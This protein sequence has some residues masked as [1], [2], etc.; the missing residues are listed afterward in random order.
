[1]RSLQTVKE[2]VTTLAKNNG[3]LTKSDPETVDL[4]AVYFQEV[5]TKEN[6]ASIPAVEEK[7]LNWRD[8]D[9]DFSIETVS[10]KLQ[11]LQADKSPGPDGIHPLLLK[12]CSSIVALPLSLIFRKSFETGELPADWRAAHIVPIFKKGSKTD[13]AN[14]RPVSLTSVSCKVMESIIKDKLLEFLD[15]NKVISE[16]QHGFRSGRSCLTNLLESFEQWTRA[17]DEGFGLDVLYLDFR[18]AFDSV[19]HRRLI[20]KLKM[21]GFSGK[22]L[23]WIKSFLTVR[24][25]LVGIRGAFSQLI[26]VLSG[27]PQGSVLDP[28]LSLLF[29]NELPEWIRGSM[30]MFADDTKLWCK[31]KIQSDGEQL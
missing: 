27:V 30:K 20:E 11:K 25:M 1:M 21:Y 2:N 7:D 18:K 29:V 19:P 10:R 24:T 26:E 31:I 12:E 28:L 14:Y 13:K 4:L 9:L 8:E 17:L 3:E 16:A 5:F 15:K 23:S 6:T 22:L